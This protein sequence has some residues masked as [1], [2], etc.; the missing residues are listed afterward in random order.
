MS[1]LSPTSVSDQTSHVH[2]YI[3]CFVGVESR[4]G[5]HTTALP[6]SCHESAQIK[7]R[8]AAKTS[9]DFNCTYNDRYRRTGKIRRAGE[10]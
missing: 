6:L 8:G 9:Q 3:S 4:E 1:M 10:H 5:T 7:R 2:I